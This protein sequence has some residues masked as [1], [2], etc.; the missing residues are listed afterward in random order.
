MLIGNINLPAAVQL[1]RLKVAF[2][3]AEGQD[4]TRQKIRAA[5][6]I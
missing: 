2:G 6:A 5:A 4:R 3:I 1:K